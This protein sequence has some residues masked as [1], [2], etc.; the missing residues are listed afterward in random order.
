MLTGARIAGIVTKDAALGTIAMDWADVSPDDDGSK[1]VQ[2]EAALAALAGKT[3][4]ETG[5]RGKNVRYF[6]AGDVLRFAALEFDAG[7][8]VEIESRF[9][10]CSIAIGEGTELIVGS[11]GVLAGCSIKGGGH[12]TI[13]GQ[14]FEGDKGPGIV[15]PRQVVVTQGGVLVGSVA[16]GDEPTTFGFEPGSRL[17]MKI[18][19][20][21]NGRRSG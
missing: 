8:A 14:F 4:E 2:G 16:Q 21:Q 17:R 19:R 15:G 6:G 3:A 5:G 1:R 7:A 13:H 10:Q 11:E 20:G 9:E 12:I 18:T